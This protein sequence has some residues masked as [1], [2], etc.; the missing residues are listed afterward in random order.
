MADCSE[1]GKKLQENASFCSHCGNKIGR[2]LSE[3]E[4]KS[5]SHV[6]AKKVDKSS[7]TRNDFKKDSTRNTGDKRKRWLDQQQALQNE[8]SGLKST[9]KDETKN[10]TAEIGEIPIPSA[11]P[12][13]LYPRPDLG[14]LRNY[15]DPSIRV[16]LILP[17]VEGV[18]NE[19]VEIK[20]DPVQ[21]GSEKSNLNDTVDDVAVA[22]EKNVD[23]PEKSNESQQVRI[24]DIKEESIADIPGSNNNDIPVAEPVISESAD[25]GQEQ[26]S[27][28][29]SPQ[30]VT[31][32]PSSP[33]A[34]PGIV[35]PTTEE[36]VEP[37]TMVSTDIPENT[38]ATEPA[39]LGAEDGQKTA[40]ESETK[41]E[42]MEPEI[43]TKHIEVQDEKA[44]T[45]P[46][47]EASIKKDMQISSAIERILSHEKKFKT[48]KTLT[49]K[50]SRSGIAPSTS[51][52]YQTD[53][54][55]RY[56]EGRIRKLPKDFKS[57][58]VEKLMA[59]AQK[60]L[61][62]NNLG[63][64]YSLALKAKKTFSQSFNYYEKAK[65]QMKKIKEKHHEI[66]KKDHKLYG[67][68][69]KL[70]ECM[71]TGQYYKVIQQISYLEDELISMEQK[72]VEIESKVPE[73]SKATPVS[74]SD[75]KE[76]T[77]TEKDREIN[78]IAS[79]K[80]GDISGSDEVK[81]AI[82]IE[83][84]ERSKHDYEKPADLKD[85][86]EVDWTDPKPLNKRDFGKGHGGKKR[87]KKKRG[88]RHR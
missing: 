3:V 32:E 16:E 77:S 70:I 38:S 61:A 52:R 33:A 41:T 75:Q 49:M 54:V 79:V 80:T 46:D 26:K 7:E 19:P 1:C 37:E 50:L 42:S 27:G 57:I 72:S 45:A 62:E 88:K 34:D 43:E 69:N 31:A 40:E 65:M 82:E 15:I 39:S 44:V 36:K 4:S 60:A 71:N 81:S 21:T 78:E 64:A 68:Y 74:I 6:A 18:D 59:K 22:P 55:I 66:E 17:K 56:L 53:E 63:N 20:D 87:R 51:K 11:L 73:D 30:E 23:S 47:G 2:S 85:Q 86:H 9:L 28:N 58:P 14:A 13:P 8:L 12:L 35:E 10:E 76:E 84:N 25:P 67:S 83:D 29:S 48:K 5:G 24:D